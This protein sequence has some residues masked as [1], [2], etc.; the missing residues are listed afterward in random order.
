LISLQNLP[1]VAF[2]AAEWPEFEFL[3]VSR[4]ADPVLTRDFQSRWLTHG[5]DA[6]VTTYPRSG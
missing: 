3:R 2:V 5:P 6:V 1:F 4:F